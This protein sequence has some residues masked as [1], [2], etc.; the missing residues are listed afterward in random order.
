M[1]NSLGALARH[2]P[3][4]NP[5]EHWNQAPGLQAMS[6]LVQLMPGQIKEVEL[7]SEGEER[8][9]NASPGETQ[10]SK[11]I[12]QIIDSNKNLAEGLGSHGLEQLKHLASL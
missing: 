4:P 5:I 2:Q 11:H 8:E 6:S 12:I 10:N 3:G 9:D 7:S 1:N